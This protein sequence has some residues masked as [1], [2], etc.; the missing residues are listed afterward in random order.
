MDGDEIEIVYLFRARWRAIVAAGG[1]G[2]LCA[3]VLMLLVAPRFNARGVLYL[4]DADSPASALEGS[5]ASNILGFLSGMHNDIQTQV[6]LISTEEAV[7]RAVLAS[8]LNSPV[9]REG[10]AVPSFGRWALFEGKEIDAYAPRPGDV[11]AR[12]AAFSRPGQ[13]SGKF[14]IIVGGGGQFSLYRQKNF[15]FFFPEIDLENPV[16][17]GTLGR[18]ASGGGVRLLL[19]ATDPARPPQKGERFLLRLHSAQDMVE[20]MLKS[21]NALRV[22]A[23]GTTSQQTKVATINFRSNNPYTGVK[24]VNEV[25]DGFIAQQ[26]A[27]KSESASYTEKFLDS[28]LENVQNLLLQADQN[29]ADYQSQTG[30]ID[31]PSNSKALIDRLSD[32]ETQKTALILKG[33]ALEQL[34]RAMS[35]SEKSLNPFLISQTDDAVLEKLS[36]D[37][38]DAD[39]KLQQLRAQFTADAPEVKIQTAAVQNV[40]KA[41]RTLVAN[42]EDLNRSAIQSLQNTID[43]FDGQLRSVPGQALKVVALTRASEVYSQLFILLTQKKEEAQ[44]SKVSTITNTRVV[45]RSQLP[46]KQIFP[47]VIVFILGGAF[48]GGFLRSTA[49]ILTLF[50]SRSFHSEDQ[51]RRL[52]DLPVYGLV[53]QHGRGAARVFQSGRQGVFG[54]ALRLIRGN[55]YRSTTSNTPRAIL[56]TSAGPGEGKS[57]IAANLAKSLADDGHRVVVVDCDLRKPTLHEVTK[58][59]QSPGLSDWLTRGARPALRIPEGERFSVLT[60]GVVPPNPGELFNT[61][62]MEKILNELKKD[63]EFT[64]IDTPPFPLV[65][66]CLPLLKGADLVLSVV[67]VGRTVRKTLDMHNSFLATEK[68]SHGMVVNMVHVE[69]YGGYYY[70]GGYGQPPA[71]GKGRILLRALGKMLRRRGTFS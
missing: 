23:G 61:P 45:E 57:L 56:M 38:A 55:I 46:L 32:Y 31:L 2:L 1:G 4:G 6:E 11:E 64:I 63:F 15:L 34:S 13:I 9:A 43:L 12:F 49:M 21:K 71:A 68:V 40:T 51:I 7:E 22:E 10:D 16:L 20:A 53:P 47:N 67:C 28:Q 24:F 48:L 36:S 27:W 25:M 30:L 44:I 42:D 29:L 14:L 58:Q 17:T 35:R 26:L 65:S 69:G 18:P 70:S 60:S 50:L 8:G 52:V 37:L 41:I 62:D 19:Q 3:V 5:A 66:D 59:P 39:T 54:E 33:K